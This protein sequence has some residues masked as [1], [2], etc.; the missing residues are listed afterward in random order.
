[1]P[2]VLLGIPAAIA[3]AWYVLKGGRGQ[4]R[5]GGGRAGGP[6]APGTTEDLGG[7]DQGQEDEPFK[8][9]ELRRRGGGGQDPETYGNEV[10]GPYGPAAGDGG[11]EGTYAEIPGPTQS[12]IGQIQDVMGGTLAERAAAFQSQGTALLGAV[13]SSPYQSR[14]TPGQLRDAGVLGTPTQTSPQ[15]IQQPALSPSGPILYGS[16]PTKAM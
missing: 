1:M 6:L 15:P 10:G 11:E 16:G 8:R 3:F 12:Y 14:F 5:S 13:R 9:R 7:A 2:V 4:S